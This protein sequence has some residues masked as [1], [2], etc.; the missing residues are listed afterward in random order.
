[1]DIA[2][3]YEACGNLLYRNII[4][5][6]GIKLYF[7]ENVNGKIY[8]YYALSFFIELVRM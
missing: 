6:Q 2:L 8:I 3:N 7:L 4:L 5:M 1:M